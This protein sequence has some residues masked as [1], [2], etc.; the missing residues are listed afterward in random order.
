MMPL[1]SHLH[2]VIFLCSQAFHCMQMM[3]ESTRQQR[4]LLKS[5]LHGSEAMG[6]GLTSAVNAKH[7]D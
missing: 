4:M 3:E 2:I 1:P 5:Q 6:I 7:R